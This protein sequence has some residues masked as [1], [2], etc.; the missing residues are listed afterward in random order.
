MKKH[1]PT[2]DLRDIGQVVF[3]IEKMSEARVISSC[4]VGVEVALETNAGFNGL[5]R[6]L[7]KSR[8]HSNN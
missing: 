7:S 4:C 5:I 1:S 2:K 6:R 8:H 3:P